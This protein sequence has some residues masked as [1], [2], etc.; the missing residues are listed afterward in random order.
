VDDIGVR[1]VF[2]T[3]AEVLPMMK[4]WSMPPVQVTVRMR[5]QCSIPDGGGQ[6]LSRAAGRL[7]H[8]RPAQLPGTRRRFS[9]GS[10][11]LLAAGATI[12]A[13]GLPS[14]DAA[15]DALRR[16]HGPI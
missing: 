12:P 5:R 15:V 8:A 14:G 16:E 11:T 13:A 10:R 9:A 4:T 6:R 1:R 7:V 2:P 3:T